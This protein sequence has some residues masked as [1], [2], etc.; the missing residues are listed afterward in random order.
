MAG[1]GGKGT[2]VKRL[3]AGKKEKKGLDRRLVVQYIQYR[4]K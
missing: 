4:E 1:K 2:G 3:A